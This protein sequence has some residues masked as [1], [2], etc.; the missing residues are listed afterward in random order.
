MSP[1]ALLCSSSGRYSEKVSPSSPISRP[2]RFHSRRFKRYTVC[3]DDD[4]QHIWV[5]R[6]LVELGSGMLLEKVKSKSNRQQRNF[7]LDLQKKFI[8]YEPSKKKL[9]DL[10]IPFTKL[11]EIREGEKEYSKKFAENEKHLCF[12]V[13]Y[14][15]R[16]CL[17]LKAPSKESRDKW[18]RALRFSMDQLADQRNATDRNIQQAFNRADVNDDGNLD[19]E[20]VMNLMHV[21]NA[22]VERKYARELFEAADT[23]RNIS[24][25]KGSVLDREEFVH[26]YHRLTR[27]VEI[28]EVYLGYTKG[29]GCMTLQDLLSF[30]RS[31][32]KM[33]G[34]TEDH[35]RKIIEEFETEKDYRK[36]NQLSLEAFRK[37]LTSER[38]ELFNPAHRVVYQDMNR[39]MTDYL[40]A[41]SHNTYLEA[42]QLTGNSNV[43][44][45]ITALKKGCRCVE[46]D[47]WDGPNKE[48]IIYHGYTLT[49]KISFR[50]VIRAIN[51]YAFK[52]SPFPVTLSIENHCGLEQQQAMADI[53]SSVFGNKLWCPQTD[54]IKTPS[55]EQLRNKIIVKGKRL[56]QSTSGSDEVSDE[57]EAAELPKEAM[58]VTKQSKPATHHK[59]KLH[60]ALSEVTTMKSIS[61]ERAE[62]STDPSFNV[63]SLSES[64]LAKMI[65]TNPQSLNKLCRNCM[66]RAYPAGSRTDSSNY[67]PIPIWIHGVQLVAL[68]Y[69]TGSDPMF[70]NHGLFLDNGG[71]GYVLKPDF[72]LS[73]AKFLKAIQS[74]TII[75]K[76]TITVI[77]GFQLPKPN[78]SLRGEIIDP[79]IKVDILGVPYDLAQSKTRAILNNGF[80]P[81]WYE[82]FDFLLRRPEVAL[83][84][85]T[86]LDE[87][88]GKDDFI[89]YYCLPVRCI[90][91][92]FR[93]FPIYDSNG[94]KCSQALIFVHITVTDT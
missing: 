81:R 10:A 2:P 26:F 60:P 94:V 39:P 31:G 64:R 91:E 62:S 27:R 22:D 84:K 43:E 8:Y 37:F 52:S 58:Q 18:V 20:E 46:L 48:P 86:V 21:L 32:Q 90:Q 34:A 45:Y 4:I 76:L 5:D 93:H 28:E 29:K 69:Q 73:E 14:D 3:I 71:S 67:N 74:E 7:C 88:M 6:L 33:V 17:Y 30:L 75:R 38:Q 77:S 68:N 49:S 80:N 25:R 63:L 54:V 66:I 55:P 82:T 61:F 87:D 11:K 83:L 42:D 23:N 51:D 24:K 15:P 72:M 53:M 44:M 40:I 65:Q 1:S 56:P 85:F 47:C 9:H 89:G 12:V 70:Y 50:S 35:C 16:K 78:D 36:K 92:G 57:D 13:I 79:F 59:I 41:S 19:F